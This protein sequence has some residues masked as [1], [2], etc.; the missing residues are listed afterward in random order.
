LNEALG[1]YRRGS[2]LGQDGSPWA[3][4]RRNQ[5]ADLA[6]RA[7]L[8]AATAAYELGRYRQ[9]DG[10][11]RDGLARNRFRESGWRLL[12]RVAA[13]T[14]DGDG[15]IEAFRGAE[16]ALAEIGASPSAATVALLG[17]LRR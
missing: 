8:E 1:I 6:E 12:M 14:H 10:L 2:Y 15:V 4:D 11:A 16:H 13:A 9:A 17:E 3:S 5:L 7:L